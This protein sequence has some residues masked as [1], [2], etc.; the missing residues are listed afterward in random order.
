MKHQSLLPRGKGSWFRFIV[1][2]PSWETPL[3][4]LHLQV[5]QKQNFKSDCRACICVVDIAPTITN[6]KLF[7][8]SHLQHCSS[9][10]LLA[11]KNGIVLKMGSAN[12]ISPSA[13]V[14]PSE[15]TLTVEKVMEV[16]GEVKVG[17]WVEVGSR[18]GV[19]TLSEILVQSS[20]ER[21]KSRAVGEYWVQYV[22]DASWERLAT[23]L[24]MNGEERA[25]VMAKQY[26]PKGIYIS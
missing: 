14:S 25:A 7:V 15:F 1:T 11:N 8:Q 12:G 24:Y 2:V 20:T 5:I 3:T 19:P 17:K 22:P 16:M 6:K 10:T 18:L 21:E 4:C 9:S 13:C 26:L 23:A